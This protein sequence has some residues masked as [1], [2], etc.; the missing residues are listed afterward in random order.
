MR[1]AGQFVSRRSV[2]GGGVAVGATLFPLSSRAQS[3]A[4][5][6]GFRVITARAGTA[7]LRAGDAGPTPIRGFDGSVPGPALRIK[8]GEELKVRLVNELVTD[9]TL[10]WHGVRVP[11]AMDGVA[12]LTQTAVP[13]GD[14]FDYRFAPPDA[15]T[16]WYYAPSR[17]IEDRALYG[18]LI[19][20]E[21]ERVDVDRDVGLIL[22]G[23]TLGADGRID[24]NG[25][26]YFT[27]NGQPSLDISVNTNERLRLRLVNAARDRLLTVRI[28]R[29]AATVVAIDGQPAE[30]FPARDGRV[31]L[32]PGN[33]IDLLIDATLPP[34]SFA[35][36]F[37]GLD[38]REAPLARLV[39]LP[40]DPARPAPRSAIKP[41]PENPLPQR[42]NFSAAV[43]LD[44]ALD[45]ARYRP[46]PGSFGRPLF[47]TA[48]RQPIMI[49]FKNTTNTAHVV[50]LHGHSVRLLDALDDGW[51]PYW[52]DTILAPPQ[53]TTRVAF[54][55]DNRGKWLIESQLL[56][57][58]GGVRT[59]FEVT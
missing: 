47:T 6:D 51:K 4:Q 38:D 12:G 24:P 36:I 27:V 53:R 49:G 35:P 32:A 17:F 9:M 20:D 54:V 5:P 13:P 14:S 52:L 42:M 46:T 11:N 25:K 48:P 18:L 37:V 59:W 34:N 31:T 55:A 41:L 58:D 28:D 56:R 3:R 22:D 43:K 57:G 19:V 1:S 15:G 8:R 16:F 29:H 7:N 40:V 33:R 2:I 45:D 23:W 50:H 39:Y 10:H 30:P 26:A 21:A 44:I